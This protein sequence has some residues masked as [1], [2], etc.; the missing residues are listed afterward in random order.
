EEALPHVA[1][2]PLHFTLGLGA[3]GPAGSSAKAPMRGKAHELRVHD[4]TTTAQALI[5]KHHRAHLVEQKLLRHPT[6]EL[7]GTLQP[8][9]QRRH[10]LPW[11]EV[12]PQQP[13]IPQ[14][15]QQRVPSAPRQL[16]RAEVNLALKSR[17]SLE[18]HHR[19]DRR[20]RT[21]PP[22]VALEL[23]VAARITGAAQLLE[24]PL[25]GEQWE[26]LKPGLD[27]RLVRIQLRRD[28]RSW[29][30]ANLPAIQVTIQ[31]TALDP[32]VHRAPADAKAPRQL[33]LAHPLLQIV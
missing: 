6:E 33:A 28:G 32:V 12:H 2:R 21:H 15:H 29:L 1:D 17:R 19:F 14:D 5:R 9:D 3:I 26:S 13:R 22:H 10:R 27:D 4:E 16:E 11:I 30:V 18:A 7:K 20:V 25:S 23:R 24:Q 8:P 31:L